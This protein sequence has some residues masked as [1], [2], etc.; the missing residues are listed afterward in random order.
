MLDVGGHWGEYGQR[1]RHLRYHGRIV[2]FEPVPESADRLRAVA[3]RD[4]NWAVEQ[5]ALGSERADAATLNVTNGTDL[6]SFLAPND[7]SAERFGAAAAVAH[8]ER[9][10]VERL[11]QIFDRIVG[12]HSGRSVLLKM[13]TQGHDLAVV[14]GATGIL[15]N[16]AAIQTEI[17][18]KAL[19]HGAPTFLTCMQRLNELGYEATGLF[20][21]TRDSD[22]LRIIE[23]D[24]VFK[25]ST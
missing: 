18:V 20:P 11:D 8:T 14:D 4:Q 22:H 10:R 6:A 1:L 25:R 7:Y 13:D 3:K 5:Y 15:D 2:S 17:P 12:T 23:V 16:V 21:V 24:A 19:Y 9:V